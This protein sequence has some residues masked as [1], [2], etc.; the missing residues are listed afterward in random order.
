MP[1]YP[2]FNF[3]I[4]SLFMEKKS[5]TKCPNCAK[6]LTLHPD[7]W[8]DIENEEKIEIRIFC[9]DCFKK[10]GKK[11]FVKFKFVKVNISD[12]ITVQ[13]MLESIDIFNNFLKKQE[14]REKKMEKKLFELSLKTLPYTIKLPYKTV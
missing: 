10:E 3:F 12:E 2:C 13:Q 14:K 9:K 6:K 1:L 8:N 11:Y 4:F 7:D 5:S